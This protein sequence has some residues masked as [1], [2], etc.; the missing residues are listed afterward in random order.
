MK[1]HDYG[2][3]KEIIIP[4]PPTKWTLN[5]KKPKFSNKGDLITKQ[6]FY[7]TGNLFYADRTSYHITS[8]IINESKQFLHK[9]LTGL[10]EIEKMFV[11]FE[12][13]SL[14]HI[15]LDNKSSFWL[16]LFFDIL[17][18]PTSRQ[19]L[20]AKLKNKPIIST[21]T[22]DDDNTKCVTGFSCNFETSEHKMVFRIYGR[23]KSNQTE[24]NLF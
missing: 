10:P 8:K 12:Y 2:L 7:L 4:D 16:K 24:I 19:L 21:K 14:K 6:D 9:H 15:D 11:E 17:K 13:C 22:I 20:N 3:I 23:L 1:N 5:Y 18:T